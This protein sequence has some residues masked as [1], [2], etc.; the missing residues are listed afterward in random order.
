MK[1]LEYDGI[2]LDKENTEGI[3]EALKDIR[4]ASLQTK[5]IGYAIPLSYAIAIINKYKDNLGRE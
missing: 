1:P 5:H 2:V 4:G 3:I